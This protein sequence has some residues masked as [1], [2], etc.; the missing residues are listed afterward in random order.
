MLTARMMLFE[1]YPNGK[2]PV[3]I[4]KL[5]NETKYRLPRLYA[6]APMPIHLL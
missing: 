5:N 1:Y 2:T 6:D 4:L 3:P